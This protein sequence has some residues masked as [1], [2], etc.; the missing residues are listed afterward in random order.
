[1]RIGKEVG[2]GGS[3]KIQTY[4]N[5]GQEGGSCQGEHMP[6]NF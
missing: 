5:L 2:G 4:A 1:M 3:I 6:I